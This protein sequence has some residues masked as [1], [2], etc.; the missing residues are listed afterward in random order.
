MTRFKEMEEKALRLQHRRN[1]GVLKASE[2]EWAQKL[3][4]VLRALATVLRT[5]QSSSSFS[6]LC[7]TSLSHPSPI[8][9]ARKL[10]MWRLTLDGGATGGAE[11]RELFQQL[12]VVDGQKNVGDVIQECFSQVTRRWRG[13]TALFSS[14]R[15]LGTRCVTIDNTLYAVG[16]HLLPDRGW[17]EILPA[18]LAITRYM[19]VTQDWETLP[20]IELCSAPDEHAAAACVSRHQIAVIGG[21]G[22]DFVVDL[23]RSAILQLPRP[24]RKRFGAGLVAFSD[25]RDGLLVVGGWGDD[26]RRP[27]I[28]DFA[29]NQWRLC[30]GETLTSRTNCTVVLTD[31]RRVFAIGGALGNASTAE[32]WDSRTDRWLSL[33]DLNDRRM[34]SASVIFD[35]HVTVLGGCGW[36]QATKSVEEFDAVGN[37]WLPWPA[38]SHM[39]SGRGY[40]GAGVIV[41]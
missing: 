32:S 22:G 2:A 6:L 16:G 24:N 3:V 41:L 29:S 18:S 20:G 38:E 19:P 39:I 37:R 31:D 34:G 7:L 28:F 33:P 11:F 35:G 25:D 8:V 10:G 17:R 13:G 14:H 5:G 40:F 1:L 36:D 4:S 23:L 12:V 9:L 21:F 15:R 26:S 30:L 27:E